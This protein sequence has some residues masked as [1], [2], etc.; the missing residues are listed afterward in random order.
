MSK[1]KLFVF[2]SSVISAIFCFQVMAGSST[3]QEEQWRKQ[4]ITFHRIESEDA[5][6]IINEYQY[7]DDKGTVHSVMVAKDG[8]EYDNTST[9]ISSHVEYTDE[10]GNAI[11]VV[12][13]VNPDYTDYVNAK[14]Y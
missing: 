9:L 7:K 10:N 11:K 1:K 5:M 6:E 14:N 4:G 8:T 12:D 2:L 13:Y 3:Y